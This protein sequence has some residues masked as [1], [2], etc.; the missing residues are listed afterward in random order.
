VDDHPE[1]QRPELRGL[2]AGDWSLVKGGDYAI[3][4][5]QLTLT[6]ATVA[7]LAGSRAYGVDST[8]A[9]RFSRGVPWKINVIT[10]GPVTQANATGDTTNG[11]VIPTQFNGDVLA[12]MEA[13]YADGSDAGPASWTT[14]Q[15]FGVS[16]VPDS[17]GQHH[18]HD[19][20]VPQRDQRRRAGDAHLLLLERRQDDVHRHQVGNHGYRLDR[21]ITAR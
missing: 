21:L 8:L 2:S 16:F 15:E 7:R 5:D 3:D 11:L 18:H 20:R 1:P 6:A 14:Y 12:E 9:V 10:Y 17:A 19:A 13:K 4:G